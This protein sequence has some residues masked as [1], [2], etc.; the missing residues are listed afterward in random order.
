MLPVP[1]GPGLGVTLD[2]SAV[3]RLA[4]RHRSEGPLPSGVQGVRTGDA[5]R[6]E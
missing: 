4:E 2:A 6:R 1:S 5:F 3:A